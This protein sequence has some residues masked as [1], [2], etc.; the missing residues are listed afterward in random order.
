MRNINGQIKRSK[1]IQLIT[2]NR[3][4][5][6]MVS[7]LYNKNTPQIGASLHFSNLHNR[8]EE[9]MG[10]VMVPEMIHLYICDC[11]QPLKWWGRIFPFLIN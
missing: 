9:N 5:L 3:K 11:L 8:K 6:D 7:P 2:P 4:T 10:K 1:L